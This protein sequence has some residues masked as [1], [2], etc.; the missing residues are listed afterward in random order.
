MTPKHTISVGDYLYQIRDVVYASPVDEYERPTGPGRVQLEMTRFRVTRI[1]RC[2]A[3][4][5]VYGKEQFG[6]LTGKKKR[7]CT[8]PDQAVKSFQA[9]KTQ[10]IRILRRQ[11]AR[12]EVARGLSINPDNVVGYRDM[13]QEFYEA[14]RENPC[15][16]STEA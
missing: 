4:V 11:L 15:V 9:R 3:W 12:A 1:T 7:F 13:S 2:G 14:M 6:L 5:D 10:Q 8:S 16:S